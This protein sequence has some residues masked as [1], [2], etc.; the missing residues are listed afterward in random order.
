MLTTKS[1]ENQK[2]IGHYASLAAPRLA[3]FATMMS[4]ERR[5]TH[6]MLRLVL[7]LNQRLQAWDAQRASCKKSARQAEAQSV[8][9]IMWYCESILAL[10]ET[11]NIDTD[12]LEFA[13]KN[14]HYRLRDVIETQQAEMRA[15]TA[16]TAQAARRMECCLHSLQLLGQGN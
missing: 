13:Y 14:A 10:I 12:M 3:S 7:D 4:K 6:D 1:Y 11:G 5:P 16:S 2:V 9:T 15:Y 8:R